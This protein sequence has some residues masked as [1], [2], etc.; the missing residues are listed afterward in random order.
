MAL[1]PDEEI[2]RVLREGGQLL[3]NVLEDVM[4]DEAKAW[5]GFLMADHREGGDVGDKGLVICEDYTVL[6]WEVV[7]CDI[8]KAHG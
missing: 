2:G 1:A 3:V 5:L 7:G 8:C 6:V 4:M